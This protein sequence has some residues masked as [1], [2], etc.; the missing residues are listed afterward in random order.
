VSLL[1]TRYDAHGPA[2]DVARF[3]GGLADW[4][5]DPCL[6][7][8]ARE[9]SVLRAEADLRSSVGVPE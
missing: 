1:H 5:A 8:A 2:D 4:L 9:R 7:E 3:L 6:T